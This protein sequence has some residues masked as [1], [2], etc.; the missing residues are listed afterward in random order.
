[1]LANVP[2]ARTT[3]YCAEMDV[4]GQAG[5][6]LPA[7]FPGTDTSEVAMTQFLNLA[8]AATVLVGTGLAIAG[9]AIPTR[10]F[11]QYPYA[12]PPGY[13]YDAIYGCVPASYYYGPSYYPY[14]AFGF[15]SLYG[16]R[17]RGGYGGGAPHPS[18]GVARGEGGD[19][20]GGH[21]H[22]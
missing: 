1:M 10:A 4:I 8:R 21:G 2:A 11:A 16:E 18:R 14:P 6:Q 9:I 22:R 20:G 19:R 7:T 13:Y 3:A 17:G 5:Q 12:C 15:G